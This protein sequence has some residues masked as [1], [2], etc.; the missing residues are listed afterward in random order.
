MK[1]PIAVLVLV[2]F[3]SCVTFVVA[4]QEKP[5][6]KPI[7]ITLTGASE[8]PGPGD[9]DGT[10]T[11]LITLNHGQGQVC[12]EL[13]V[14]NIATATAAHIHTGATGAAGPPLVTFKAPAADCTS[15]DCALDKDKIAD[16]IK[17]P[18]GYYV[19]VHN[20]EFPDGAVRGQLS[21]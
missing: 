1:Q 16:I 5:G 12:Y 11:A 3:V 10:G 17:H 6:A 21:K 20:A 18:A 4:K 19:K 8:A 2:M 7:A 14:S 9:P 15:K 13:K